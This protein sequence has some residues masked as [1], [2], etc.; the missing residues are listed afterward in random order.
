MERQEIEGERE[1][2]LI[3]VGSGEGYVMIVQWKIKGG[4]DSWLV[5]AFEVGKG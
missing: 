5:R 1:R 2:R 3:T 4:R